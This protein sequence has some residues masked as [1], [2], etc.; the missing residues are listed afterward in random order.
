MGPKYHLPFVVRG[1]TS[2]TPASSGAIVAPGMGGRLV[3]GP[4]PASLE[5]FTV[6]NGAGSNDR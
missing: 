5:S 4:S 6:L 2:K 3:Q 1:M